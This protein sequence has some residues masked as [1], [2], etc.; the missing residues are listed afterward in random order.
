M[1]DDAERELFA[2]G[3]QHA[4]AS[5]SGADLDAAL[6]ALGWRDALGL[7][8]AATIATVFEHQG[9]AST[10]SSALD[11]VLADRARHR[12]RRRHR[13]RPP[14]ARLGGPAGIR[15][16]RGA[17]PGHVGRSPTG[18]ARW[19]RRTMA[20]PTSSTPRAL[21]TRPVQGIDPGSAS[22]RCRA[23][24]S[25]RSSRHRSPTRG[26]PRWPPASGPSPTSSSAPRG[27]CCSSL[28]STPS[29][30]CSSTGRSPASRPC[31]TAS[32]RASSPSKPP[33]APPTPP[34][35]D[36]TPLTAALAKAIAGRS[37]RTVARHSQ[38]VLAGIGFT[39]EHPLHHY[40]RR[41]L[42]LDHLLGDSRSLTASLGEQLLR[43]RRLPAP[44]PALAL[45]RRAPGTTPS[46][47]MGAWSRIVSPSSRRRTPAPRPG[48]SVGPSPASPS[49]RHPATSAGACSMSA[50]APAS[51]W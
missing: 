13:R 17:R 10:T 21:T 26:R 11:V 22:S 9:A 8:P 16:W 27:P 1:M 5:S 18:P 32:P 35:E 33:P 7:D 51:T 38:Q 3:I 24:A 25:S 41:A 28:A 36:G 40:V 46:D 42:V 44:L 15:G 2:K 39:T 12:P 29:S 23:R 49:S 34:A 45:H 31:V 37:A 4:T 14:R 6:D 48:T 47:T 20:S 19:S 43:D 50:A 30:G